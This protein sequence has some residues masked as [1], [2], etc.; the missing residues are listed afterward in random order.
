MVNPPA[1]VTLVQIIHSIIANY[2]LSLAK[3][4]AFLYLL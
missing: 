4:K 1:E 2:S 3:G